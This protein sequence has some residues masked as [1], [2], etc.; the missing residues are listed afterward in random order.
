M[1]GAVAFTATSSS[2]ATTGHA[3]CPRACERYRKGTANGT[4]M[5]Y[6]Q[7][8][9]VLTPRSA[10]AVIALIYAGFIWCLCVFVGQ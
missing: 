7:H 4:A 8:N 10:F 9:I 6:G 2:A 3:M 1:L 5:H